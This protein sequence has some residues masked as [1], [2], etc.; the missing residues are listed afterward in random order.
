MN[1]FNLRLL[2][3]FDIKQ[4]APQPILDSINEA[5]RQQVRDKELREV[6]QQF[7]AIMV[8]QIMKQGFKTARDISKDEND[9]S[10]A[11]MDMAYD[12]LAQ[13]MGNNSSM[14]L[15]DT[16]FESLKQQLR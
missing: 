3:G 14:G 15:A 4:N 5:N 6:S 1:D 8:S 13:F 16:I 9:P 11:F 2:P 7:E 10:N 12:Q